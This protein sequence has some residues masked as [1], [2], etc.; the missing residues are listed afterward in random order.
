M[1]IS[2]IAVTTLF[3]LIIALL[4]QVTLGYFTTNQLASKIDET[5][6][7]FVVEYTFGLKNDDLYMPAVVERGLSWGSAEEKVGFSIRKDGEETTT[8][9]TATGV[10]LSKAPAEDGMYKLEGGKAQKLWLVVLYKTDKATKETNYAL[11]VD[12]L[13][14]YV[15]IGKKDL[16]VRQLNPSE[17][18]YYLTKEVELNTE[19]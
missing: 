18:K 5:T 10:V 14:F 17:L 7:L 11:Q 12:H 19:D 15:D 8:L 3:V 1:N 4:P 2:R 16:D 9:G 13:P 6:A